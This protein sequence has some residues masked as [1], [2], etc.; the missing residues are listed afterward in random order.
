M[1]EEERQPI[2]NGI[3]VTTGNPLSGIVAAELELLAQGSEHPSQAEQISLDRDL[4]AQPSFGAIGDVDPNDLS[5]AGW[6]IIFPADAD[7]AIKEALKPLL[8]HRQAEAGP[9]F[10]VFEG[11]DGYRPGETALQWM[12]RHGVSMNPVDPTLGVPYYLVVAGSP[13]AIPFEFQ[14][15]LDLYWGVGRIHF[16]TPDGYRRYAERVVAYDQAATLPHGRQAAIFATEH[17]FDEA[18]QLFTRQVAQP[19]VAADGPHGS[20]GSRQGFKWESFIGEPA[21]KESLRTLFRGQSAGGPPAL[22]LTGTHGMAIPHGDPGHAGSQGALVCQDW[23]GFGSIEPAHWFAAG[24]LADDTMVHGLIH[25]FFACYGAGSPQFDT[26]ERIGVQP[27]QVAPHDSLSLLPLTLLERGALATLGHI[28]RA[29]SYSFQNGRAAPQLQGFRDVIGRLL[30]GER[31]G[32]ATDQFN[33]RWAALSTELADA[34]KE[35]DFDPGLKKLANRWVARDDARNY[36]I[37]GDPAVRLR[38]DAM[39]PVA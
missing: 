7:P 32:E 25:F 28:D 24:D 6:G 13:Q 20:P 34:M 39:P 3:D 14:Y 35:R 21:T 8:D 29:W 22:L 19:M 36:I 9:L 2:P 33:V 30:R 16:G 11:A 15:T 23:G 26:F 1:P 27:K 18:T 12:T 31:L 10:K 17:D 5:Q 37:L 4:G 38:V